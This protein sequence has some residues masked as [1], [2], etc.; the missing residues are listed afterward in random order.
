MYLYLL[1]LENSN[2]KVSYLLFVG[3]TLA[4]CTTYTYL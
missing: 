4:D 2:E 3:L 1:D